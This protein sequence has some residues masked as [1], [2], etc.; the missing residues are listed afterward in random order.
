MTKLETTFCIASTTTPPPPSSSLSSSVYSVFKSYSISEPPPVIL[1]EAMLLAKG[2]VS[3]S[4]ISLFLSQYVREHSVSKNDIQAVIDQSSQHI[5]TYYNAD[6]TFIKPIRGTL[7][8]SVAQNIILS[9]LQSSSDHSSHVSSRQGDKPTPL[10][11]VHEEDED[12]SE[13][14]TSSDC[15]SSIQRRLEPL[16]ILVSLWELQLPLSVE[17]MQECFPEL[18]VSVVLKGLEKGQADIAND[19]PWSREAV[20]SAQ[21]SRAT[22]VMLSERGKD[23]GELILRNYNIILFLAQV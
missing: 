8:S 13:E 23:A 16:S 1:Y 12:Q 6:V 22:S 2:F 14:P 11:V 7:C 18:Q 4:S 3:S 15:T 17:Y 5:S 20:E 21:E 10:A 19:Y 9:Q